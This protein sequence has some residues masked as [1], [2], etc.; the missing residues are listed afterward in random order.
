MAKEEAVLYMRRS[1]QIA[2]FAVCLVVCTYVVFSYAPED[3]GLL[4][5]VL[6]SAVSGSWAFGCLF[7]NRILLT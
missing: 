2:W 3:W 6:G 1:V 4:R 5:K 7:I